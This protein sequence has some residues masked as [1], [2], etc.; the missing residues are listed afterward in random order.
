[1]AT[2]KKTSS[3][4]REKTKGTEELAAGIPSGEMLGCPQCPRVTTEKIDD[5]RETEDRG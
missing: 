5:I 2:V 1:M 4:E 3:R